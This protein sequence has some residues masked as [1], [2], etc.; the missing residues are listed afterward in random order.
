MQTK[1]FKHIFKCAL[2]HAKLNFAMQGEN[3]FKMS[4]INMYCKQKTHFKC[5]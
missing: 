1:T 4:N 3:T 5:G 2:K